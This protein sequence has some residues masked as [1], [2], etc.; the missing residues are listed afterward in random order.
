MWSRSQVHSVLCVLSF[1]TVASSFQI[2][3][4][5]STCVDACQRGCDEIRAVQASRLDGEGN[6]DDGGLKV[7]FKDSDDPR[8]AL[9]EAD[10]AAQRAIVGALRKEWGEDLR[11]IGEEDDDEELAASILAMDFEPLRRDMFDDD[12]GETVDIDPSE[13]TV[14]VDPL[15]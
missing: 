12:I 6:G 15:E 13:I 1:A 10:S 5:L 7:E 3:H 2:G 11:I 9:T 4:L 8:S 14:F